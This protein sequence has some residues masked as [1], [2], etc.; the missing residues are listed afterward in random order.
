MNKFTFT[1]GRL[2]K[3]GSAAEALDIVSNPQRLKILVMLEELGES[4]VTAIGAACNLSSS[5]VGQQLTKLRSGGFVT[6]EPRGTSR[7]YRRLPHPVADFA[8]GL[9]KE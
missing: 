8:L 2:S 5:G 4:D 6:F 3:I 1:P 7:I 9:V